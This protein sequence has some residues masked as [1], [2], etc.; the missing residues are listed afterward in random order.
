MLD[1]ILLW[2]LAAMRRD[3]ENAQKAENVA[4]HAACMPCC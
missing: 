1:L 3:H 4:Q 2:E